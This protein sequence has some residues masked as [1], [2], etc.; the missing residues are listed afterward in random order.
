MSNLFIVMLRQPRKNDPR[1]DPFWEFGSFGC[2]GCHRR[3]LLHPK[4]C[5]IA[6][7]DLLAFIQGGHLGSR[8]LLITPPVKRI[9]HEAATGNSRVELRW[10]SDT[11]PFRYD[12]APSL[13]ESA[14]P[15]RLGLF[16]KLAG[17]VADA[18]RPTVAAKFA[19]R[20]RARTR[21]LDREL[22]RELVNGFTARVADATA[23]DFISQYHDALPWCDSPRSPTDRRADYRRLV[24]GL[25]QATSSPTCR[26]TGCHS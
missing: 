2:T 17:D 16:P 3:N 21:P 12:C 11:K 19:S 9:V 5:R 25:K 20:F 8:L 23:S 7:G 13:F 22:A 6:D 15:R 10:N 1:T 18:N 24:K 26:A 14:S 4:L